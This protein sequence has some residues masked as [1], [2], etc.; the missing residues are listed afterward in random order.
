MAS[1]AVGF[2]SELPPT[3]TMC[4]CEEE[5][6][7]EEEMTSRSAWTLRGFSCQ[8]CPSAPSAERCPLYGK[9]KDTTNPR[10]FYSGKYPDVYFSIT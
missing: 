1:L 10:Q 7:E 6:G 9:P 8:E 5:E 4:E 2:P 3:P